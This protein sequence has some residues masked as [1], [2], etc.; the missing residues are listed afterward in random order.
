QGDQGEIP[1]T[2]LWIADIPI[3]CAN[4]DIET[5]LTWQCGTR[6]VA[7]SSIATDPVAQS[8]VNPPPQDKPES[9]T[10]MDVTTHTEAEG[11]EDRAE[12]ETP[13]SRTNTPAVQVDSTPK[14]AIAK[15]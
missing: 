12:L 3:S 15:K 13:T 9:A 7:S 8:N 2:K 1:S 5:A 11:E 4:S 10:T 6:T 14:S